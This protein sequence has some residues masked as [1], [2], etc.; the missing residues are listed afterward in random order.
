MPE[1]KRKVRRKRKPHE[2]ALKHAEKMLM[3]WESKRRLAETKTRQ[4]QARVRYYSKK[5]IALAETR[6]LRIEMLELEHALTPKRSISF[7]D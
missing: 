1:K 4:W 3:D 2:E 6:R 5:L 7:K